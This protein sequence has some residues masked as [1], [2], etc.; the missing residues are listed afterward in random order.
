MSVQFKKGG[1][2]IQVPEADINLGGTTCTAQDKADLSKLSWAPGN[3]KSQGSSNYVCTTATDY[4]YYY[5]WYSTYTGNKD[6]N[7]TDPCSKLSTSTYGSDW[8]T[9]SRNE[10][11]KLTRCTD[12]SLLNNGGTNGMW[13]MNNTNGLFLPAAGSRSYNEGAGTTATNA[14]GTRGSYWSSDAN[15]SDNGYYLYFRSGNAFVN[16][17]GK[18][19]G[20]SVRC[21]KG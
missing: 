9:P 8:R 10:M 13:F 14:A 7:N 1:P 4:G 18:T 12:K 19:F 2:G 3:L 6:M 11:E 15:G 21:V 16:T 17:N 20:Y 5:T